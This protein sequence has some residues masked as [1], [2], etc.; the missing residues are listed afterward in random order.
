MK[1]KIFVLCSHSTGIESIYSAIQAGLKIDRLI[2]LNIK[3]YDDQKVSGLLNIKNFCLKYK[4]KFSFVDS[5]N[6]NCTKS[7]K[8]FSKPYDYLWIASW[9]RLLPSYVIK[10]ARIAIVGLHGSFEGINSGRG[11]S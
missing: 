9:Q 11:R 1:N 5:Y 8:I 2:G 4:I 6:L 3:K 10:S 7:K